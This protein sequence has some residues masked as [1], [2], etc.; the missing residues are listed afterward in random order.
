LPPATPLVQRAVLP[1]A[2]VGRRTLCGAEVITVDEYVAEIRE[3]IRARGIASKA[4]ISEHYPLL[5]TIQ[6]LVS[7]YYRVVPT[8][9][10]PI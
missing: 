4:A 8:N 6:L 1:S 3:T 10:S 2:S 9:L 7:G 5:R